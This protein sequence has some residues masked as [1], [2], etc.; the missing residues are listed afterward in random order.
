[1]GPIC[2]GVITFSRA[3]SALF[4][5]GSIAFSEGRCKLIGFNFQSSD[6]KR[7][8]IR[9]GRKRGRKMGGRVEL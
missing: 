6:L 2:G 7:A 3:L 8:K 4:W 9:E 1:M 5:K